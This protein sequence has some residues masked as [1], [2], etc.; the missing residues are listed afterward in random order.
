MKRKVKYFTEIEIDIPK[1]F[2][3]ND[4][5]FMLMHDGHVCIG[6]F[7]HI[8]IY[9]FIEPRDGE[10]QGLKEISKDD[11]ANA[12]ND[13]FQKNTAQFNKVKSLLESCD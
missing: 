7:G 5:F 13:A 1:Y 12:L 4:E 9:P 8:G 6:R 3:S 11:F 10:L 2:Y